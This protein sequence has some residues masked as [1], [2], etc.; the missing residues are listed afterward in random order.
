VPHISLVFREMW[1]ANALNLKL[2]RRDRQWK[3]KTSGIPNL[4]K[5]QRDMGHPNGRGQEESPGDRIRCR[6]QLANL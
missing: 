6:S 3:V 4:A 2:S 5:N 1:D